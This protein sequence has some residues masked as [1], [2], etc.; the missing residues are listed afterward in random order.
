[1]YAQKSSW[2]KL[3]EA[4]KEFDTFYI[5]STMYWGAN[6]GDPDYAPLDHKDVLEGIKIEHAIKSSVFEES[7]NLS[8]WGQNTLRHP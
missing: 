5:Y 3:P 2:Y 1:M 7:T 4:T 8:H 6:E